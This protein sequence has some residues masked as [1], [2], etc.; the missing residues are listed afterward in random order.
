LSAASKK[1]AQ[2][3]P[4]WVVKLEKEEEESFVAS[5]S[6]TSY[7]LLA[8]LYRSVHLVSV[9]NDIIN[10]YSCPGVVKN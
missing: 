7:V 2:T 10:S 9:I 1:G 4:N 3:G 5:S 8:K 6:G